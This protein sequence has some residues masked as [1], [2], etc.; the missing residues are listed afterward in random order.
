MAFLMCE[1]VRIALSTKG[2]QI[3]NRTSRKDFSF[4]SGSESFICD[5]FQA[6]FLSPHISSLL[7]ND[8]TID[9]FSLTHADSRSFEVISGLICGET[10]VIDDGNF[11][12]LNSLIEDVGN[13]ELSQLVLSFVDQKDPLSVTNCI[14]RINRKVWLGIEVS[15]ECEFISSHFFEMKIEQIVELDICH[16][17]DILGSNS[18]R[19]PNEDWLFEHVMKL[20]SSSFELFG[21]IR[22][23]YLSASSIDLFFKH[24]CF[25]N[26]DSGI[27]DQLWSRMR[28]RIVFHYHD[29]SLNRFTDFVT[30]TPQSDTPFS[31]LICH[32]CHE[33][34][35][36]VHTKG[37]IDITCSST[38]C[39]KCWQI[40]DYDWNDH[41]YTGNSS[42][43]WIQFDFK[44]RSVCVTHYALKSGGGTHH[45]V[46]WTFSGSIDETSWTIIDRQ[47]TQDL[48]GQSLTKLF[49][50]GDN[51]SPPR[52]YRYLRLTQTGK[53]SYGADYLGLTNIDFFGSLMNST[54]LG[55]TIE[56]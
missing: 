41:F 11:D 10:I 55:F 13:S 22:F 25:E 39:N 17:K 49:D 4:V 42:N 46:D 8:A 40:V 14:S 29:L 51:S 23:E 38:H 18:L 54:T 43:S 21:S 12:I 35:G 6:A 53:N 34:G 50:C 33:C 26:I 9:T 52:F 24:F 3:A 44:D 32:L 7:L 2:L 56:K 48:N 37:V 1:T 36:N 31:G 19:I 47:N 30:R 5:R 45:L 20:G 28:H 16:L 27:W 15:G